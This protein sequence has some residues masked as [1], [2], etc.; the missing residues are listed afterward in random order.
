MKIGF[1][2]DRDYKLDKM[3]LSELWACYLQYYAIA[4]YIALAIGCAGVLVWQAGVYGWAMALPV[5]VA[6]AAAATVYPLVWYCLHR[7][8]LHGHFLMRMKATAA[9][10][11]RI[12]YDHHCD[13][14]S[15]KI[16]FGALYTTLP[17][18]AVATIPVGYA[19]GLIWDM[20]L[21]GAAAAFM[22]GLV[23][24][25]VY[26][27]FHCIE[28]L[29]YKPKW[30]WVKDMKRLHLIHHFHN[31]N[32]NMG[33]TSYYWDKLLGTYTNKAAGIPRSATVFNLGYD[34]DTAE[35]YP[36]VRELTEDW[37]PNG[38]G[39]VRRGPRS[40]PRVTPHAAE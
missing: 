23:Q 4:A 25:C 26:E 3:S 1:W 5:I 40:A 7:W 13:P 30:Q 27:F 11:K 19:L 37:H 20:P 32:V 24:T 21:A 22:T 31:E 33:I 36:Y 9:V 18:I 8:V 6:M 34:Q 16:L 38:M 39:V 2:H 10:W 29:N 14:N 15:L 12:H 35:R 28:H 17:T